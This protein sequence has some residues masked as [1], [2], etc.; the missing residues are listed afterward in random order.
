VLYL[1]I[2]PYVHG[3]LDVGDGNLM[4]FHLRDTDHSYP[5]GAIH[6]LRELI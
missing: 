2:D 1:E 5:R 6:F 3:M 4:Y